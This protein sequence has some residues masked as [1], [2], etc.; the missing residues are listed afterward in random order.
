MRVSEQA[1]DPAT[2]AWRLTTPLPVALNHTMAVNVNDKLSLIGGET[3]TSGAG[4]FVNTVYEFGAATAIWTTRAPMPT[5]RSG[6]AAAVLNGKIY[7]AGGRPP[8]GATSPFTTPQSVTGSP[9]PPCPG[10]A[11]A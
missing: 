5:A 3:E 11:V 6:G 10:P 9:A 2:N 4:P 8:P 1:Y 7:V